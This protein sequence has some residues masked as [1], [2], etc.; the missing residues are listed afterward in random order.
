[1]SKFKDMLIEVQEAVE[2]SVNSPMAFQQIADY[3]GM[4]MSEV[5]SI[6]STVSDDEYEYQ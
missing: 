3:Y 4:T 5:L 1:M 6:A 2:A